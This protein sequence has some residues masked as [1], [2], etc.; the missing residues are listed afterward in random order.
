MIG[1]DF[2]DQCHILAST[3]VPDPSARSD[4]TP[5]GACHV[6]HTLSLF[7]VFLSDAD[8][9]G[10]PS[11]LENMNALPRSLHTLDLSITHRRTLD[12][13]DEALGNL[14]LHTL[15]IRGRQSITRSK[16]VRGRSGRFADARGGGRPFLRTLGLSTTLHTLHL[17][18]NVCPTTSTAVRTVGIGRPRP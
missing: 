18:A 17:G 7:D 1:I 6:L 4:V 16:T 13:D 14:S 11:Y 10:C 15:D 9:H 2:A 12:V 8:T 3:H 5:L